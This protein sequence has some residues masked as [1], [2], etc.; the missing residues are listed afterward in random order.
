[1][2]T[3]SKAWSERLN[4]PK[5]CGLRGHLFTGDKEMTD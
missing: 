4:V 5:R 2:R 1:M 3:W